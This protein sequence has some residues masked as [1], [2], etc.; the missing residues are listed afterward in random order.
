MKVM[1]SVDGAVR[2]VEITEEKELLR[3]YWEMQHRLMIEDVEA[4]ANECYGECED[5]AVADKVRENA[6]Y[7]VD[8]YYHARLDSEDNWFSALDTAIE[9]YLEDE[10]V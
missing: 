4:Y 10:E 2:E 8:E 9:R 3:V 7:I 1:A 5:P 6:A